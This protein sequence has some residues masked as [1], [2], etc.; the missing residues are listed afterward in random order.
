MSGPTGQATRSG[1]SLITGQRKL[2]LTVAL[3]LSALGLLAWRT[4]ERQEDPRLPEYF[5]QVVVTFPGAEAEMVERLVLDPIEDRLA[6]V[7]EIHKIESSARPE[8][9]VLRI[10]L[11]DDL[12]RDETDP[13][14]DR[15]RQALADARVD[16]PAAASEPRLDDRVQDQESIVYAVS[17]DP[18]PLVLKAAAKTLEDALLAVP[19]VSR[20]RRIADPGEQVTIEL[21]EQ[22]ARRLG[23]SPEGLA[24]QL[25]R[26][27]RILPGGSVEV[28]GRQVRLRPQSELQSVDDLR[29]TPVVLPSGATVPLGA[30][31][32]VRRG[33]LE[34]VRSLMRANGRSAVGL[35]VVPRRGI[36][37]VRWGESVRARVA[38]VAPTL[39]SKGHPVEVQELVFQPARVE[40]R[41]SGLG[42]SLLIGA[43]V[44]AGILVLTMGLRVGLVVA[45]IVPLVTLSSIALFDLGGGTLHQMSIA[46][47]V[48]A[49]G[50]LVDNAIVMADGVQWELDRL[51]GGAPPAT[52]AATAIR[53]LAVPLAGA[54][55]T[56]LAAFLPMLLSQ[57]VTAEF[58]RAIPVVIMLTLTVS[59]VFAVLVTPVVAQSVLRPRPERRRESALARFAARAAD[60]AVERP[61]RALAVIGLLVAVSFAGMP[62]VRKDFF[63]TSDRNQL[64]VE[65]KLPEGSHLEASDAA[66][67]KLERQLLALP[68]VTEVASFVGRS[69]PHFYYNLP[70]IPFSPDLAQIMVE[71][72]SLASVDPV[73][74]WVREHSPRDLPGVQVVVHKLEQGPPVVAPVELRLY[75]DDLG[76]LRRGAEAVMTELRATP[77]ATDARNDLSPGS[78][79]LRFTVDDVAAARHGLARDDI[80][81]TLYGTT[82]GLPV[83]P[84]RSGDDPVPVVVR[85]A[86]GEAYPL[87]ELASLEI[88]RPGGEA[89]PLEEV[90]ALD[91]VW[92]PGEIRHRH[93]RRVVSVF[94]QLEAGATYAD[95]MKRLTPRLDRLE[96]PPGVELE[97]GGAAESSGEANGAVAATV[98]AGLLVLL[99]VLMGEFRSF[100]RV[101]LVL[102][103]VP[104][105]AAGIVPGLLVGDQPFGFMSLLGLM[106]LA[107]VVVN[108]AIVLIEAIE[109]RRQEGSTVAEAVRDALRRRTRPIL[110]TAATTVLGLTPL[111]FSEST[112][113]PP[114]AWTMISGLAASTLLTLQ[115]VPALY[116]LLFGPRRAD[117]SEGAA[118]AKR[119]EGTDASGR[120]SGKAFAGAPAALVPVLALTVALLVPAGSFGQTQAS[121]DGIPS[122]SLAEAVRRADQRPRVA[123]RRSRARA[124]DEAARAETRAATW[125]VLG[126]GGEVRERDQAQELV[127]PIGNFSFGDRRTDSA[128]VRLTQPLFTPSSHLYG[129]PA[130]RAESHAAELAARRATPE[131]AAEAAEAWLDV[132]ATDAVTAATR[133]YLDSLDARLDQIEVRV[134]EGRVLEADA[135]KVR[136]A[137]DDA[138]RDLATL[139]ARRRVATLALGH[140][141][142]LDGPAEPVEAGWGSGSGTPRRSG[143][144]SG[145][146]VALARDLDGDP[147]G[148]AESDPTDSAASASSASS[149]AAETIDRALD[150]R[151][152]LAAA[153][154]RVRAVEL[155]RR[156]LR[157]EAL[158]RL[159]AEALW[160]WSDGTPFQ[161]DHWLEAAVRVTWNPFAAG[162]RTPRA[163][164]LAAERSAREAELTEARRGVAREVESALADLAAARE[165]LAVGRTGV[166]QAEETL[167]IERER[168]RA[169]RVTVNDLLEAEATLREQTTRRELA[170]LDVVRAHVRLRL[171]EGRDEILPGGAS[172]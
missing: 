57:G 1:A 125:P 137:R 49:L 16:L 93:R 78:P 112:L 62:L 143:A 94:A 113:W 72:D 24:R 3:L 130:A 159:D 147:E 164:A 40:A 42:R 101:G 148:A 21:G 103:T 14:W 172:R 108:N 63:P 129:L 131:A 44:V 37:L 71:T 134:A 91:P 35:G 170:A 51:E 60:F 15:V 18:D 128:S 135:L 74:A 68:R 99:G 149:A 133:S 70:Q 81:R 73:A 126:A 118:S 19:G 5:G 92:R 105:A 121:P 168:Y 56:T 98:P 32:R 165:A 83:G 156:E 114:L 120:D 106:A 100:R 160:T 136:L 69:T 53:E 9:A 152:D 86:A 67:R 58:T 13:A 10:E 116:M 123:A 157:A 79:T 102:V 41:L 12:G 117:R 109:D 107:G 64:V 22:Q 127:T 104:L 169:G 61:L 80:A 29:D 124:A 161:E 4:M 75:G 142:G 132:A 76:A 150:R 145:V 111:A 43:L 31:A 36:N 11:R 6:Q 141:I 144:S 151:P 33:P 27:N 154:E 138:R 87:S 119:S 155:R 66:A 158:P 20:V 110:L 54:T 55:A 50:M 47:I 52:A 89:V 48:I 28:A 2:I 8:I 146:G 23:V 97:V 167:R 153:A 163:A 82:R 115:A 140:A 139:A 171:A 88:A 46:A 26:R 65:L 39:A 45:S 7:E 95:V 90:A 77:G 17:G 166:R 38:Q 84:L 25:S 59:Y 122:V 34:P 96:L 162:T 85:G 30:V